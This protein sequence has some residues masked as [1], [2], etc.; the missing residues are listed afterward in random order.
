MDM[1]RSSCLS[2]AYND[3]VLLVGQWVALLVFGHIFGGLFD[4]IFIGGLPCLERAS[5]SVAAL[6]MASLLV[7]HDSAG[8]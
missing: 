2:S 7:N 5:T 6:V 1:D 3:G 8:Q 4:S